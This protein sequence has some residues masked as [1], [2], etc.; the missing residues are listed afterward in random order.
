MTINI[1]QVKDVTVA[2]PQGRITLQN[3]AEFRSKV[4]DLIYD[5]AKLLLDMSG[6]PSIDSSGVGVLVSL[7]NHLVN[8]GRQLK[9]CKL[10]ERVQEILIITQLSTIF[11]VFDSEEEGI[12]SF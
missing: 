4:F 3:D 5:H 10:S 8:R 6:V 9:L 7:N 2:M 12:A 1:K 11:E